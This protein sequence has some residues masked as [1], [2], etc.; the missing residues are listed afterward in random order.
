VKGLIK[1]TVGVTAAELKGN[2]TP[3]PAVK[4]PVVAPAPVVAKA[5][6]VAE[7]YD[8]NPD[9]WV[10]GSWALDKN[11]NSVATTSDKACKFCLSGAIQNIYGKTSS[12]AAIKV[13]DT[14]KKYTLGRTCDII[15]FN[16][17]VTTTVADIRRVARLAGI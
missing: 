2:F 15:S 9:V 16:D 14:I 7:L 12:E 1:N 17:A 4:A 11:G 3:A 10:K 8:K 6:T 13:R 5:K